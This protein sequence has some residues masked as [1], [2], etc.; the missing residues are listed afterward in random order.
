MTEWIKRRKWYILVVAILLGVSVA[1][2]HGARG[3]EVRVA[4]AYA[5]P[6]ELRIAASGMVEQDSS[7]LAFQSAGEIVNLYVAEGDSVHK[8]DLLARLAPIGVPLRAL[9]GADTIQAPYDGTVVDIYLR[10]GSVVAPGQ[11]VLRLVSAKRPWVTAFISS[12]DAAYM[13]PGDK[14]RCRAGGY[15]SEPW[16][17]VV[18]AVGKEAVTRR[19]LPGSS[20]QV[21]VRCDV[22]DPSFPLAPGTE[23]D[24]DGLIRPVAHA[25]L[26]PTAAVL[27]TGTRDS[28]WVVERNRVHRRDV[29]LGPNNFEFVQIRRGLQPGERV[30]VQGKE[31]LREGRKVQA[32]PLPETTENPA[33]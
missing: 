11:P 16:E 21:R 31:G 20:R 19:D 5:G 24:I 25:T 22:V 13:K 15:L 10:K 2:W 4:E 33:G 1:G 18:R 3:H 26:I 7:D 17:L 28:V 8:S 12:E 27:H 29:E 23:V 32:K 30:V 9:G 6:L 14:L